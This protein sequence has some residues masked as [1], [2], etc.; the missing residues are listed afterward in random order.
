MQSNKFLKNYGFSL[1][2]FVSILFGS[3]S[4]M[5]FKQ[6]AVMFKPLGDIFLNLLFTAVVP[7]VFFSISSA[8]AG[9]QD[10]KRLAKILGTMMLIFVLTG[11]IAAVVMIVAVKIFPLA[12]GINIA[13]PAPLT[14]E[15]YSLAQQIVKAVT[16][17][18]FVE[19][20]S[21][22]NM[23]ALIL[24]SALM[25]LAT[26]FAGE[27]GRPFAKFL[28]SGNV[29]MTKVIKLIMFY[30]PVGLGAYFAYLVGVFGPQL[31]GSYLRV[32]LLYYPVAFLYF[33]FAFSFYVFFAG[34]LK[35]VKTFWQNMI[36]TS[37]T[38]W[39][40]GS[41]VATIPVNLEAANKNGVPQDISEVVIPLGATIHMEGSCLAAIVK[42]SLLFG[43]FHM[44]FS[45]PGVI[46][47]AMGIA[48]LSGTVMSGI[49]G[50]GFIGE[51]LIVTLYGFPI[52]ALPVLAM[53]GTIV[54]P[55][56]TMVNA[57]GDNV[58]S[59]LVARV[60]GGKQWRKNITGNGIDAG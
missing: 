48:L 32:A 56:A 3:F 50:G 5:L 43:I 37:L 59:M 21:K 30:A 33:I 52:E 47:T 40:T 14:V 55:P 23:L 44:D 51:L 58:A 11:M 19:I 2:L 34:G 45:S 38:A 16:V 4:G 31:M 10:A 28:V 18:D 20:F 53:V 35:A 22:K 12:Q 54:D 9:M 25:G 49:P 57:V 36:S 46:L 26:L 17:T 42:I 13:L 8:I 60:L 27:G 1:I 6:D 15:S 24:F 7:L 41:S 39:A 29:V